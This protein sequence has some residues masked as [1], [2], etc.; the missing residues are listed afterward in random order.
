[1]S[2][3]KNKHLAVGYDELLKYTEKYKNIPKL[4]ILYTG[5]KNENGCS[6]CSDCN[7]TFPT[8]DKVFTRH[9][10]AHLIICD[11]GNRPEWK[12]PNNSFRKNLK[13]NSI[14]TLVNYHQSSKRLEDKE[15]GN[16]E[17]LTLMVEEN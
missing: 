7:Q 1:M 8:I 5:S 15:C 17:L 14:P 10:D 12:D 6:W 2:A 4:F 3:G 16:E 11:V 9:P 13:I